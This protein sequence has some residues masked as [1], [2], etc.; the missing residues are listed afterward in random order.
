MAW[1]SHGK[2]NFELVRNLKGNGIIKSDVV[3][4]AMLEVDRGYYSKASPYM[5]APQGI[6]Y[7]VTISAPHMHAHALELLKDNL[8][9][10]TKALD[11]GSGSGY[12]TACMAIMM[13]EKGVAVGI[14]HIPELVEM[15]RSNIQT[16]NPDLLESKRVQ[17]MVGD[18]RQ[19]YADLAPYD[20]IHV[21]AAAPTLPQPLVDQLK[22]GGRLIVPV[23]PSGGDQQLEQIDKL[24]DG[25]IQRKILM[26][27]V[28]VP[29]TDKDRQWRKWL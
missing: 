15:S 23:G 20:A 2:S 7:G 12:L 29:L 26:G 10:G 22:V 9:N 14:D 8:V 13:G 3:E 24:S 16:A 1:R 21:G 19:G 11:V 25:S 28:Y 17:L 18:G 5:D 27:V 4:Q 6:G